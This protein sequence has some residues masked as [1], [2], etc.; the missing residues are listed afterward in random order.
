MFI[1]GVGPMTLLRPATVAELA[2]VVRS[3]AADGRPIFPLGGRTHLHVGTSAARY[4]LHKLRIGGLGTLGVITQVTLK[5][6]PVPETNALVA[7]GCGDDGL[8][9]LLD[10]LHASRTRPVCMEVLNAAAAEG[11]PLPK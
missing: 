2:D 4:A 10:I 9:P 7:L 6:R 1:D 11:L 3:C 5:L 8:G